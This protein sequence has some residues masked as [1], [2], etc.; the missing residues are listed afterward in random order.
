MPEHTTI[1]RVDDAP[2]FGSIA[3]DLGHYAGRRPSGQHVLHVADQRVLRQRAV[4]QPSADGGGQPPDGR[5]DVQLLADDPQPG[6][7]DLAP[8]P[9][10]PDLLEQVVVLDLARVARPG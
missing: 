6:V 1:Q 2:V 5:R 7:G 9:R 10:H 8:Q 4:A 3:I